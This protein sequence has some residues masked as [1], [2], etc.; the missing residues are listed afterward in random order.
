MSASTTVSRLPDCDICK[1]VGRPTNKIEKA[2]YDGKTKDG[3]W[4]NMCEHHFNQYGVGLGTGKGQRLIL[5]GA[6]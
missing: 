2:A 4:A 6:E 5:E 3:P 1:Y